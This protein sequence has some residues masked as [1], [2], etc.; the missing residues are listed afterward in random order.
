[1]MIRLYNV[2]KHYHTSVATVRRWVRNGWLVATVRPNGH[3]DIDSSEL[4][5]HFA[6]REVPQQ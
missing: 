6:K 2:P 4:D 5:K 3:Y 1:M